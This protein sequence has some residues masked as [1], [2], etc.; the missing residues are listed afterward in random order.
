M[1]PRSFELR[2]F[3]SDV[4]APVTVVTVTADAV[5]LPPCD[6][7]VSPAALSFG[8]LAPPAAREFS[9]VVRNRLTGPSDVC[10]L[11]NLQ[12]LPEQG[13]PAGMPP[14]VSLVGGPVA[15]IDLL[16]GES[17]RI[18]V[19]AW[20][21]GPLPAAPANVAGKVSFELARPQGP[22]EVPL[23]ATLCEGCVAVLPRDLDFGTAPTS[24]SPLVRT[25][26]SPSR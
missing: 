15:T 13:T 12:L 11:N 23:T 25:S 21:Q 6:V 18:V 24:R 7:E 3:T 22:V 5:N 10:R 17:R 19:R 1:G 16:P 20:P 2:L 26:R 8:F 14:V 4:N 9:F